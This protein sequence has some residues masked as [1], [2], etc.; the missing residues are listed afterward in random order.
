M[1]HNA[2]RKMDEAL[3]PISEKYQQIFQPTLLEPS[4]H[5]GSKGP[6]AWPV[7]LFLWSQ[8]KKIGASL[9]S[10]MERFLWDLHIGINKTCRRGGGGVG[11]GILAK[12][13]GQKKSKAMQ[14]K[15]DFC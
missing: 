13:P 1:A 11:G 4:S 3:P 10:R 2:M 12:I 8:E 7:H 5:C 15:M 9:H 6:T 14:E